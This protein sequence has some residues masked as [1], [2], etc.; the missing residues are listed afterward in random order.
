[1]Q[2]EYNKSFYRAD[3]LQ[4]Y[5]EQYLAAL[6]KETTCL[7]STGSSGCAIAS[8]ILALSGDGSLRHLYIPKVKEHRHGGPAY[9]WLQTEKSVVIVDDFVESGSTIRRLVTILTKKKRL[10]KRE[11][12]VCILTTTPEFDIPEHVRIFLKRHRCVVVGIP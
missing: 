4:K 7:V 5:A 2:L 11:F 3:M 6:P 1:M 8:A 12:Q 10:C 9:F